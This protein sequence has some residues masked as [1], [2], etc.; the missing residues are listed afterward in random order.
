MRSL[1]WDIYGILFIF[2]LEKGQ[3]VNYDPTGGF[4]GTNREKNG[5]I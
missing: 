4:Q 2:Y 5:L 3:T 1:L